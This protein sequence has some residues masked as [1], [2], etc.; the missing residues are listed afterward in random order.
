MKDED[1]IVGHLS[2]DYKEMRNSEY[3]LDDEGNPIVKKYELELTRKHLTVLTTLMMEREKVVMRGTPYGVSVRE[4]QHKDK[5][6]K[7]LYQIM[8]YA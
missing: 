3:E 2:M 1:K 7:Q 8:G 6:L 5:M 4:E